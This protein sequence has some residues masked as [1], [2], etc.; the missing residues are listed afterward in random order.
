[1]QR[2]HPAHRPSGRHPGAKAALPGVHPVTTVARCGALLPG[3]AEEGR[4]RAE[5]ARMPPVR[6]PASVRQQRSGSPDTKRSRG[7]VGLCIFLHHQRVPA[8]PV[9]GERGRPCRVGEGIVSEQPPTEYAPPGWFPDPTGLQAQRWWDGTQWGQETWPISGDEQEPQL[10]YQ[11]QQSLGPPRPARKSWPWRHK[12]LTVLG[13]LAAL[14]IVIGGTASANGNA[15]QADNASLVAPTTPTGT[16]TP[17]RA[18][19]H[20]AP[21]KKTAPKKVPMTVQVA[22]PAPATTSAPAATAPAA[23]GSGRYSC[24]LPAAE[25]QRHPLRTRQMWRCRPWGVRDSGRWGN[26][27]R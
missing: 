23:S 2:V 22:A 13:G 18:P 21:R 17:S 8:S 6:A 5:N 25:Y 11:P 24:G 9:T 1:M 15:K 3:W 16:A 12:A 10:P 4:R 26:H 27:H 14:A 19:T 20:H 7:S